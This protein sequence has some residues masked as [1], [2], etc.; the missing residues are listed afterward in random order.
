[1]IEFSDELVAEYLP[2]IY[3]YVCRCIGN[4]DAA[5]DVTQEVFV[6]VWKNF[7]SYDQSKSFKTWIFT[8]A[9]NTALDHLKKKRELPLDDRIE[10]ADTRPV[11][12][13]DLHFALAQIP[14]GYR[15]VIDFHTDGYTF[16]EIA[17][18]LNKPLNTVKSSYRRG[19]AVLRKLL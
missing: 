16:R 12:D 4:R 3:G 15:S 19:V 2:Q 13:R 11:P 17:A 18:M 7:K 5:Q 6:K 10:I 8:I 14:A 9:K 1:M